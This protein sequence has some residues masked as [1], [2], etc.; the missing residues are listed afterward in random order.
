VCALTGAVLSVVIVFAVQHVGG[1]YLIA[2][3]TGDAEALEAVARKYGWIEW[4]T[5]LRLALVST[6]TALYAAGTQCCSLFLQSCKNGRRISTATVH[7]GLP[8]KATSAGFFRERARLRHVISTYNYED[9]H[10]VRALR[11]AFRGP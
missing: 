1:E 2:E 7:H 9:E 5:R 3:E 10:P 4:L 6:H 8:Q 11:F